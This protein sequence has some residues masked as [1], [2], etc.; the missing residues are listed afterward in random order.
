MSESEQLGKT[1]CLGNENNGYPHC[2][3][4]ARTQEV[5]VAADYNRERA[6]L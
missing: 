1:P 3:K 6:L 4:K 2:T 5:H